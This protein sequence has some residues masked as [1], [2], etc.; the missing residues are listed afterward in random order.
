MPYKDKQKQLAY[1]RKYYAKTKGRYMPKQLERK[2]DNRNYIRSLKDNKPCVDCNVP[3]RYYQLDYD[4][5]DKKK[6]NVGRISTHSKA[7]I[8]KEI[9]KCDLI[10]AN[11]H[12]ERT[13]KRQHGLFI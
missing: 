10:C 11:C 5:K 7:Y 13:H 9:A 3:Y 1:Q 12:R 4:H 6:I 2:L 8:D